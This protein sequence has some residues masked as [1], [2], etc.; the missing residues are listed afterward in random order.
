MHFP[1]SQRVR[2]ARN[3]DHCNSQNDSVCLSVCPSVRHISISCPDKYDLDLEHSRQ[4]PNVGYHVDV[5]S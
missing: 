3:A 1:F 4:I 5:G 2:I